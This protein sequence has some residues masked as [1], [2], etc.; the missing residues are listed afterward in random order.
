MAKNEKNS[1]NSTQLDGFL[2]WL[3]EELLKGGYI[4]NDMS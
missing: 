2:D 4:E 3:L 1:A